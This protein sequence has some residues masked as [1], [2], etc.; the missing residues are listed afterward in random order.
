MFLPSVYFNFGSS[1]VYEAADRDWLSG[2]LLF[3][4]TGFSFA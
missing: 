2:V 4:R 3:H 1:G